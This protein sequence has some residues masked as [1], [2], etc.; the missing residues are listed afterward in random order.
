MLNC[1]EAEVSTR[2]HPGKAKSYKPKALNETMLPMRRKK[3]INI[4]HTQHRT[5]P[6]PFPISTKENEWEREK[7]GRPTPG[8][9]KI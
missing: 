5:T 8:A 9:Q 7:K 4:S 2:S 1:E 6:I 3:S